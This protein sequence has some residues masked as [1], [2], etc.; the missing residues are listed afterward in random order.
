M[1]A[2]KTLLIAVAT[3]IAVLVPLGTV[4]YADDVRL[5]LN[6][7]LDATC[8]VSTGSALGSGMCVGQKDGAYYVLTNAHVVGSRTA[9]NLTFFKNGATAEVVP[10]KVVWRQLSNRTNVDMAYIK[11]EPN[12]FR[13]I[14]PGVIPVAPDGYEM[15]DTDYIMSAGCPRGLMPPIAFEGK[16]LSDL[17]AGV[18][19]FSPQPDH[20]QS[21]SGIV[22]EL[23]DKNG[24]IKPYVVGVV[25]WK[26][27]LGGKRVG[28]AIST[29]VFHDLRN[30][31]ETTAIRVPASYEPC[32]LRYGNGIVPLPNQGGV[33]Q[34]PDLDQPWE[35]KE[36]DTSLLD[37][38]I[39]EL[40]KALNDKQKEIDGAIAAKAELEKQLGVLAASIEDLEAQIAG[41]D[42]AAGEAAE[43]VD[44]LQ[45][46]IDVA[47]MALESLNGQLNELLDENA[48]L[49]EDKATLE[50]ALL[51]AA[52]SHSEDSAKLQEELN[53]LATEKTILADEKA[54]VDASLVDATATTETL[55]L[56]ITTLE[57]S[58]ADYDSLVDENGNAKTVQ[59]VL[60]VSTIA[61]LLSN[62]GTLLWWYR[63][64]KGTIKKVKPYLPDAVDDYVPDLPTVPPVVDH[65][66]DNLPPVISPIDPTADKFDGLFGMLQGMQ[67]KLDKISDK[68]VDGSEATGYNVNN[69]WTT[70]IVDKPSRHVIE[71]CEHKKKDGEDIEALAIFAVL[72]PEAVDKLRRGKLVGESGA[73]LPNSEFIANKLRDWVR[74]QYFKTATRKSALDRLHSVDMQNQVMIGFLYQEAVECL[75]HD[76]FEVLGNVDTANAID[77]WVQCEFAK[78]SGIKI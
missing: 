5:N 36:C 50:G 31:R 63:K 42:I 10:G 8:R 60:G 54:A 40:E 4:S 32:Q 38:K 71:F 65:I 2:L 16:V 29:Q 53:A 11:I 68:G 34:I 62:I 76:K 20:G 77:R 23:R 59:T 35:E 26:T 66:V 52:V 3:A 45:A 56:A 24:D 19:K 14:T 21:G 12:T 64:A 18:F 1:K 30:K 51:E 17:N 67:E 15:P 43:A 6:Q 47:K 57:E 72:Y 33:E 70:N 55:E 37:A 69:V 49:S 61:F 75:R 13:R 41:K 9:A 58:Q 74:D 28:G 25:T 27:T 73:T 44:S 22:A 39:A 7:V 48:V 46:D 78:R